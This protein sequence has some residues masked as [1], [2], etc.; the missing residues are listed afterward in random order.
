[1][2]RPDF[3][4]QPF[5]IIWEVTRACGLACRH[6][7]A[8]AVPDRHPLELNFD[9]SL[10]LIDQ[11]ARCHPLTFVLTGGDPV[12]RPDLLPLIRYASD[13]GLRIGLSPSAT[14]DLLRQDFDKL[15]EAGAARIALSLDGASRETHDR[16]RGV[17]GTW[18]L[19]LEAIARARAADIEVQINTTITRQN[20]GEYARFVEVL[21]KI[22]PVLWSV[23]QLVPTG[24]GHADDLLS[25]DEMEALFE[26]LYD[27]SLTAPFDIK[28]TEG[29][30]YRRVVLQRSKDVSRLRGRAPLGINDGKGF[31]FVSHTGDIYPS[32]FLPVAAG[33][34]RREEL[35]D[36]YR[37][38]P[39]FRA[40]RDSSRLK[41]KC[42]ICEFKE[43]CGGSR[44]RAFAMAG[45]VFAEEPL[46]N[47]QP[48][49]KQQPSAAATR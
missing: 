20:L 16:F 46:C 9:E 37:E 5:V 45:D 23:F 32:G 30:H 24:R 13:Q 3:D 47:Y 2:P 27:L 7:R 15:R 18:D 36:V 43:I 12:R 31:V 10:G 39:Q 21:S 25:A 38:H 49:G 28:T 44:A 11:V 4:Q 19:T 17:E 26:N 41:G 33:N 34:V 42:G 1:M 14:P 40:L 35:I 6:C 48:D 22:R 8:E 29:H